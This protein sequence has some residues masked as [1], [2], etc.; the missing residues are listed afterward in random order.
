MI[1]IDEHKMEIPS[2]VDDIE[3]TSSEL[4]REQRVKKLF[5]SRKP[6]SFNVNMEQENQEMLFELL[7]NRGKKIKFQMISGICDGT[8]IFAFKLIKH[9]EFLGCTNI[10]VESEEVENKETKQ[11]GTIFKATGIR[12]ETNN[13]RRLHRLP[14]KRRKGWKRKKLKGKETQWT[15]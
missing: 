5:Y 12:W 8:L 3:L 6:I 1:Y 10:R 13:F 7:D 11:L 4:I 2:S 9:L 15:I 14:M